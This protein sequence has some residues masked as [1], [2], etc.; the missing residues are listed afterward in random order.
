MIHAYYF[1]AHWCPPCRGFT[2]QLVKFYNIVNSDNME[3]TI[4]AQKEKSDK[5]A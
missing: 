3:E 2:P 5:A 4:K 1:S